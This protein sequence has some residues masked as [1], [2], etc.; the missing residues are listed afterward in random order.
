MDYFVFLQDIPILD[1]NIVKIMFWRE[2]YMKK[3]GGIIALIAGVFGVISAGIT[4]LIGGAASA[5]EAEGAGTVV[6][7]GWGGVIFSF[8]VIILGAIC[9]GA[10]SKIPG[11]LLIICSLAG[12]ILGG[13]IVAIFMV[14]ALIAGILAV[15]GTKKKEITGV[16]KPA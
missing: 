8:L 5:F 6:G 9:I 3:A 14:L 16:E 10:K 4:L 1:R 12:A 11:I 7:L 13:T 2:I 15:I